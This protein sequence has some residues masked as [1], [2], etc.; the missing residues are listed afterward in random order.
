[1]N[2]KWCCPFCNH[3]ATIVDSNYATNRFEFNNGS[4]YKWQV[5]KAFVVVCPNPDCGEYT[6]SLSL[7]D[8]EAVG[9]NNYKDLEAKAKWNLIPFSYA[10]VLPDYVP[11]VIVE[12][13]REA[14][15]IRDLSP[16]ASATLSRR[17]L[18]GMIRDFFGIKKNRLVDEIE[19]LEDK[20]DP[21]TWAGIDAVRRIGNIG[22]H[23]EKDIDLIIDVDAD[24]AQLLINLIE[25]LIQDW[26]VV[27][28]ER[29]V[30]LKSLVN[31]ASIKEQQ[32][33]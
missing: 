16:K 14:C 27:R 10:K 12:D 24:E 23:M 28:H 11:K 3:N 29:D 22:A 15:S 26:Y 33:H 18:Q 4:K 13:Y 7:H 21:A 20:V 19:A 31:V 8:H 1:M 30:R 2:F 5:L 25:S 6:L 32:R 9:S 17:C